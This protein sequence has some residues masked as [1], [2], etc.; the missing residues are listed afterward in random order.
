M[1]HKVLRYMQEH[2]MVLPGGKIVAGV[3]GGADSMVLLHILHQYCRQNN[4]E[5]TAAHLNHS[6]REEASQDEELVRRTCQ[7]WN[8]PFYSQTADVAQIA[9]LTGK[10]LEEAGRDCRY[11]FFN[12]LAEQ[13]G[14]ERIATAHHQNDQAESVLLHLLRGSGIRG[15]QGMKPVNGRLIRPL[16]CVTRP[17]IEDYAQEYQLPFCQDLSNNDPTFMRNRI[18]LELIPYLEKAFNP[19]IVEGLNRLAFIA[20]EEN[21]SLEDITE[22]CWPLLAAKSGEMIEVD[23]EK[24]SQHPPAL[25]SRLILRALQEI[26]GFSDWSMDD[27][28][29]VRDLLGRPG[30]S[31]VLELGRNLRV[32]KVYERLVFTCGLLES[33]PFCYPVTVPGQVYLA[34]L[35]KV[36]VFEVLDADQWQPSPGQLVLD[37]E[38]IDGPLYIRS[39]KEGDRFRLP[40]MKGRKS[41]KKFFMEQKVPA[42]ERNQIPLL[43]SAQEIYA[44]LGLAI[45]EPAAVTP[46]T[47]RILVIKAQADVKTT[48]ADTIPAQD[49]RDC[50][51]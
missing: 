41:L 42:R 11:Q 47:R 12:E 35:D 15:L 37:L 27:L 1:Y 36:Y 24:L 14:A 46:S 2:N 9:F 17:D 3:S 29:R 5:L 39:R 18:R 40:G 8:I 32:G 34:E 20:R 21:Q 50:K 23:A 19:R 22:Q 13:L 33:L 38:H 16:L 7:L 44:V 26:S 4:V 28:L 25:Q 45:A 30:S 31:L 10:T 49:C 48:K 6:L 43:A 51:G